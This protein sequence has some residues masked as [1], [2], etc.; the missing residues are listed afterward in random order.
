MGDAQYVGAQSVSRYQE[1]KRKEIEGSVGVGRGGT[2]DRRGYV[3]TARRKRE[4][5]E[6]I[7]IQ[8]R[9]SG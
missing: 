3:E 7:E 4:K 2:R 1:G 5:R 6:I 9:A 8:R